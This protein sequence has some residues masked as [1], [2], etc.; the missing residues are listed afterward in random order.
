MLG[1]LQK[2]AYVRKVVGGELGVV[3]R[4]QRLQLKT[5]KAW[6]EFDLASDDCSIVGEVKSDK[7][8]EKGYA[9]IRFPRAILACRYLELVEATKKLMVFTDRKFYQRF[10]QDADGLLID[11]IEIRLV[12]IV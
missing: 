3:F 11:N 1:P 4:K 12:E 5:G 2:E 7:Y 6:H 8:T 10:K 9:T